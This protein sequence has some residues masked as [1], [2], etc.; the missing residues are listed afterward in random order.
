MGLDTILFYVFLNGFKKRNG[1]KKIYEWGHH[2]DWALC[3][4]IS[5][6][7]VGFKAPML[8]ATAP[9]RGLH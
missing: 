5:F 9:K 1:A 8:L 6:D 7:L 3:Y 2:I 4:T